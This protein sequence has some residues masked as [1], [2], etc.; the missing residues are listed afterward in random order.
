MT[1]G[2]LSGRWIGRYDYTGRA[3]PAV[4]FEVVLEDARGDL[5]GSLTEPNG[6]RPDRGATLR[7]RLIGGRDGA[8]VR[9]VKYYIGFDQDD[10][11]HYKGAVNA[12]LTRIE[13]QWWFP[14]IADWGG[15]FVMTRERVQ[16]L[17]RAVA[18]EAVE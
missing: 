16:I 8:A 2:G 18:V 4:A 17:Q 6:F 12:A 9:F 5:K 7:A 11:P 14:T 13:G 15:R 3:L 1:A 10:D